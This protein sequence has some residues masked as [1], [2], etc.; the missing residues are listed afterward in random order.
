MTFLI[1]KIFFWIALIAIIH[2]YTS[3]PLFLFLKSRNKKDNFETFEKN[4]LPFVSIIMAVHNEES[5]LQQKIQSIFQNNYP[6]HLY[7]IVIGSDAS[8]DETD[9][10][11]ENFSDQHNN[12]YYQIFSE[13]KGKIVIINEL[14]KKSKAEIIIFTDADVIFTKN[15][16]YELVKYFKD[17]KIGLIDS[18]LQKQATDKEG[19]A[20]QERLY[21]NFELS[22]KHKEGLI[23]G[24]MMGPFGGVYALRR[25]LFEPV[26]K[27][28]LVDDFFINMK[29]LEK[30]YWS[31]NNLKAIAYDNG[32]DDIQAEFKRK[33][34]ISTGN[35]QNLKAFSHLL[36]SKRILLSFCFFSH[37]VLRWLAPIFII[38]LFISSIILFNTALF[39]QIFGVFLFFSLISPIIDYF[40]R[41]NGFHI[42]LLRYISHYYYMNLGLLAGLLKYI[43]GVKTNVW[44]PTKRRNQ[45]G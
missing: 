12:F 32:T 31:I 13:R 37:K 21:M 29:V 45:T 1:V 22:I 3:Y 23:A 19:I 27:N 35:F 2:P 10:I 30:N 7:E 18:N 38:L 4:E 36:C 24:L 28:F 6:Q 44:E 41:K 14:A 5:I 26:P 20:I 43:K 16:L 11:L 40:L 9:N 42:I 34:R 8:T 33:V 17:T 25:K 15:T 39:Y